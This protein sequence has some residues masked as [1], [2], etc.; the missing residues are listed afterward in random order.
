MSP[1]QT[2]VV[3]IDEIKSR[4]L[5]R[6]ED[7]VDRYAPAAPGAYRHGHLWYT[8]N[9]GR[10]DRRVGSFVVHMSGPKAGR[11]VD[12]AS[13]PRGGDLIDLIALATG[14][15]AREALSQAR[16][17]VGLQSESP[18][19]R[20]RHAEAAERR[21]RMR[22]E[23]EAQARKE[24]AKKEAK[25]LALWLSGQEDIAGTPV[26]AYLAG[27]GIELDRLDPVPRAIRFHPAARYYWNEDRVDPQTG[28]VAVDARGRVLRD[29][30]HQEL[31]AMLTA[32]ARGSKVIDCH[33]TFLAWRPDRGWG[34][35]PVTSPKKVFGDYTGGAARLC[36]G[37]GPRGG[38]PKLAEAPE[39]STAWITEGI[40]NALSLMVLRQ[41]TGRPPVYVLAAGMV[42]NFA[43][44]ELPPAIGQVV[45][46]ADNDAAEGARSMLEAAIG[47]HRA[48]GRSVSV[49]RS[50]V[51]GEDLND[52]L[53]RALAAQ[54]GEVA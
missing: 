50:Q 38:R 25:G 26:E 29:V 48:A 33:R 6:I 44:V 16:A 27:R 23:A 20:R 5:D 52:C 18:E 4:L 19:D 2:P 7:V 54:A 1:A 46:C 28:E 36:N 15:N 32:I 40:E 42:A 49:W 10:A 43:K 3:S 8:L 39:G 14:C 11:W 37:L 12:Y 9:P 24:Q 30:K 45:L 51:Q 22:A 41:M 31:P 34:K 21:K 35:A 17:L 47:A 53:R 13:D